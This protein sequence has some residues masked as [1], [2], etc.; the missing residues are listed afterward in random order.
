MKDKKYFIKKGCMFTCS[1][2]NMSIFLTV[3]EKLMPPPIHK[4]VT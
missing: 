3:T 1:Q 4:I 2:K